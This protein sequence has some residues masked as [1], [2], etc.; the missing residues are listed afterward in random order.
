MAKPGGKSAHLVVRHSL[1]NPTVHALVSVV[2]VCFFRV[3]D[4]TDCASWSAFLGELVEELGLFLTSDSGNA[5]KIGLS[6]K[7]FL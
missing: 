5:P 3:D 2:G 7:P 4:L 1:E 6:E